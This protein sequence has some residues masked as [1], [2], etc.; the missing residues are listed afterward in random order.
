MVHNNRR[1]QG[2]ENNDPQ[3]GMRNFVNNQPD[4]SSLSHL[5]GEMRGRMRSFDQVVKEVD[6]RN[7]PPQLR[8][9]PYLSP[10]MTV[11]NQ[12][13][14]LIPSNPNRM[15][16]LVSAPFNNGGIYF[17]SYGYPVKSGANYVGVP[18]ANAASGFFQEGNGTVSIDD[19]YVFF[20]GNAGSNAA[21]IGYEGVL[22]V[23]SHGHNQTK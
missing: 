16:F 5:R 1:N 9:T 8:Q 23:E 13:Y 12:P 7:I 6:A 19:I 11:D 2:N 18:I 17:F 10:V 3:P 21:F 20:N 14:L 4:E 15:S 22:A